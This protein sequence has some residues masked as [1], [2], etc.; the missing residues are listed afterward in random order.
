MNKYFLVALAAISTLFLGSCSD[1]KVSSTSPALGSLTVSPARLY[2]GQNAT[3]SVSFSDLGS[4]VYFSSS[5][6]FTSQINENGRKTDSIP[7]LKDQ[8]LRI[9]HNFSYTV[10]LPLN[11]GT[12]SL[13][14]RTP[15]IN[16]SSTASEGESL[17]F[18]PLSKQTTI[19]VLQADAINANFGDSR[20]SV[21]GYITVS[22]TTFTGS[23][24]DA[25]GKA[26]AMTTANGFT[27]QLVY[28]FK[29]NKLTEVDDERSYPISGIIR[30]ESGTITGATITDDD[31]TAIKNNVNF[32]FTEGITE[33]LLSGDEYDPV[34]AMAKYGTLADVD[35]NAKWKTFLSDLVKV[36]GGVKSYTFKCRHAKSGA[37]IT[38]VLTAKNGIILITN[39]FTK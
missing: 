12:Y 10:T 31:V 21:A 4:H 24:F 14:F 1:D 32:L 26:S 30:D 9:P 2:T 15:S 34:T 8:D 23:E 25:A 29:S 6:Y 37:L 13:T 36:D 3:V 35:D 5:N 18:P 27:R 17:L 7:V 33:E 28:K 39:K 20:E 11:P 16:K 19:T 22:D 38:V